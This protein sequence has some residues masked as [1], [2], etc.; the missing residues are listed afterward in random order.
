MEA[1]TNTNAFRLDGK[2]ALVTG[3]GQ[4]I[5][6]CIAQI[7]ASAGAAVLVTDMNGEGA[8][9]T[10]AGICSAGG[11]AHA[12][13]QDV[14]DEAQWEAA[15]DAAIDNLGR[16]DVVVN[17]AGI[18]LVQ[19]LCDTT[20]EQFRRVEQVNVEG[21]FLG[22]KHGIRAMR[23]GGCAGRGGSIINMS[24]A[25]GVMATFA[26]SAYSA[27]KAAIR[28]LSD[29]AALECAKAHY[30]VRINTI[31][32]GLVNTRMASN[33]I[34]E[35]AQLFGISKEAE[36]PM[37]QNSGPM[38][39]GQPTD[40]ANGVLYLASDASRWVTGTGIVID[41]GSMSARG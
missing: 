3:G 16:L 41:G 4:G 20:I 15:I 12:L 26:M 17:N 22:I 36:E 37:L 7:L 31:H 13:L 40:I 24:S 39:L 18:E 28:M 29:A 27:S 38:G 25:A 35:M 34:H 5:G 1:V 23:P 33:T 10:A 14:T 2:V 30:G 11:R 6:A 19:L 9:A 21:A 8:Q 32:P